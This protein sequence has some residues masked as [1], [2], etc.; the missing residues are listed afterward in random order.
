MIVRSIRTEIRCCIALIFRCRAYN[1]KKDIH[2][3]WLS[4]VDGIYCIYFL[5]IR[6]K[7]SIELH[8]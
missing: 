7:Q 2:F 3:S 4:L 8:C 5:R 1:Q 6:N